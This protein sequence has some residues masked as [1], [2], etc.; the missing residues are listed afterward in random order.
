MKIV[1]ASRLS[2]H[3]GIAVYN[4]TL[5][6]ALVNHGHQV[7]IVTSH[8]GAQV[9]TIQEQEGVTTHQLPYVQWG[10][11]RRLPVVGRYMR[12]IGQLFYS[13]HLARYLQR[14]E[15]TSRPDVIEFAEVEGEAFAYLRR[16]Q[17]QPV[18]VRCHTPTFILRRYHLGELPFD[19][20]L[21][22]MM[23]KYCIRHAD[24]LTAPSRHMAE[25][26]ARHCN[27]SAG[28]IQAIPNALDV[29]AYARNGQEG[30]SEP[31]DEIVILHV[32][33]LERIKGIDVLAQAI[34][35]V[36]EEVP[37]ARFVFVGAARSDKK[38]TIWTEKLR[39]A[40][41]ERVSVM[42]F[43]EE[44]KLLGWYRRADIAVVPSLNYE[45]FSYTC[46]QAMA[47]GLPV[48]ASHIGGIPETV[49]DGAHGLLI[50]PGDAD[51]LAQAL[52]K[53]ANDESCRQQMGRAG[54]T[55][56]RK[57]FAASYVAQRM[58]NSYHMAIANRS[59]L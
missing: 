8:S 16:R 32:G 6:R 58:S 45:S 59:H 7:G 14:I 1:L 41:A 40:G 49:E 27:I 9:P 19:T 34:P 15:E 26:I 11:M 36:L 10:W 29:A 37:A 55:K 5:A 22:E 12:S 3:G 42:G 24:A 25:T 46:A 53:L 39:Q 35:R 54:K 21:T 33:R 23:E 57:Q 56:A 51:E 13:Y 30:K 28:Y 52:I 47:A 4:R 43:L 17:R 38:A 44:K 48:V 18:I 50:E 2:G 31:K 20:R